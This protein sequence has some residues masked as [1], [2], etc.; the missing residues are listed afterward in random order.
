MRIET[1]QLER[2]VS[3]ATLFLKNLQY[4]SKFYNK[5]RGVC[6]NFVLRVK[7]FLHKCHLPSFPSLPLQVA[8]KDKKRERK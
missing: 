5:W 6:S 2:L 4:F 7:Y 8:Q 1:V 3:I